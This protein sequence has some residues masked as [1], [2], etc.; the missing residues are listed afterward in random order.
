MGG[1][2]G[3]QEGPGG[4]GVSDILAPSVSLLQLFL[5]TML[6]AFLGGVVTAWLEGRR[7]SLILDSYQRQIF[8]LI[9]HHDLLVRQ[10]IEAGFE[11]PPSRSGEEQPHA[12][13]PH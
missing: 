7:Y 11:P 10:M 6:A 8:S 13:K 3:D 9:A 1:Q 2:G 12:G 4:T 5:A